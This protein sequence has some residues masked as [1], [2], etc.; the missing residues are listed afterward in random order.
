[1]KAQLS[2]IATV[3]AVCL[4]SSAH[5]QSAESSWSAKAQLGS[6]RFTLTTCVVNGKIY[7]MGGGN[8]AMGPYLPDVEIYDPATDSW[9]AGI[10]MPNPRMGH[11]AA[12]VGGKIYVMG[13]GY[14]VLVST[15]T[16]DEYDPATGTWA[17]KAPMPKDRVFHCAGVVDGKIYVV[18]GCGSGWN[19]NTALGSNA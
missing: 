7:A 12:V 9:K 1:M 15:A 16:L 2:S 11:A 3:L 10:P 17:T 18:G 8:E 5:V 19:S 13:G 14:E 4:G 6:A